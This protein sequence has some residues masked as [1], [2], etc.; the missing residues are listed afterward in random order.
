MMKSAYRPLWLV[1]ALGVSLAACTTP[2][3]EQLAVPP[4]VTGEFQLQESADSDIAFN[5]DEAV[6]HWWEQLNDPQLT[7][8][9]D[10]ALAHNND[11]GLAVANVSRARS[12]L[13]VTEL[14]RLPS[15]GTSVQA[16]D[17]RLA[18]ANSF[19][20]QEQRFTTYNASF[21]A[22]WELDL[23]GR[24]SQRINA[25]QAELDAREAEL[26]A[27]YVTVAAEVARSYLQLRG[28]QYRL[29]VNQRNANTLEQSYQLTQEMVDGGLGNALDVQRALAQWELVRS[30]IPGIEAQINILINR[31]GVLTGQMP[32]ALHSELATPA[33][34]P[35]LPVSVALGEPIDL[36]KRRPD[37]RYSERQL[38]AA[39]AGYELSVA[40]LYPSVNLSGSIGF[41]ATTFANLGSGG[42]LT[43]LLAPQLNWQAFNLGRV[44]A[45]IDAADARIQGQLELFEKTVLSSFEEVDNSLTSLNHEA[46]RR[47]RLFS[48]AE[49]SARAA[50]FAME[51]FESGTDS[52]LDVLDAQRTQL[53]AEDQLVVSEVELALQLVSL[54]KALGGGWQ[55]Q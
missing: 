55:L 23:F 26:D 36:L 30:R 53:E 29:D 22:A 14:D 17:Q 16:V 49:A 12:L 8:L 31:L 48:A 32:S 34:L 7:N 24:V 27:A 33:P 35:D 20:G 15:I 42:T 11:I 1:L 51:R 44:Q 43:H 45:Q 5:S 54:Y 13:D 47:A 19:P 28:N 10:A 25:A 39:L 40:E 4:P 52:Y 50:G 2:R 46:E 18:N 37:I 38:A 9:I 6:L 21:D 3:Y 41:V